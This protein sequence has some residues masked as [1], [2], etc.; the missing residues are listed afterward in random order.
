MLLSLWCSSICSVFSLL[1]IHTNDRQKQEHRPLSACRRHLQTPLIWLCSNQLWNFL[2]CFLL[3]LLLCSFWLFQCFHQ[4]T[5]TWDENSQR[6]QNIADC[7]QKQ[8]N[9]PFDQVDLRSPALPFESPRRIIRGHWRLQVKLSNPYSE[10]I[11]EIVCQIDVR[12]DGG[13]PYI[14]FHSFQAHLHAISLS[15][16]I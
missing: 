12:W 4:N 8:N 6:W 13:L 1:W 7:Y 5:K 14:L 10:R 15:Q 16:V 2:K 9:S 3:S 11:S